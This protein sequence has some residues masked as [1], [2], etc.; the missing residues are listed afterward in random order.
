MGEQE[1]LEVYRLV[2]NMEE[3]VFRGNWR[4]CM[5]AK[6]IDLVGYS[7]WFFSFFDNGKARP[8]AGCNITF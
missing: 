5:G 2:G 4:T 6:S 3:E 1:I 7:N 8:R